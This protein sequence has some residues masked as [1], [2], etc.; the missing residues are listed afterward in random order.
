MPLFIANGVF[1]IRDMG[2][3]VSNQQNNQWR[4]QILAG[5]LMGP[6]VMGQ[7]SAIIGRLRSKADADA[8]IADL[9]Y[10]KNEFIKI[11]NAPQIGR[12]SCRER[13]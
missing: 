13:V 7:V 5:E 8:I 1:N 6:R 3:D 2:T 10:K 4:R 12:A 9:D 11:T